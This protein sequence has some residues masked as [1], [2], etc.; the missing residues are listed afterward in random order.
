M[1]DFVQP[2]ATASLNNLKSSFLILKSSFLS[3]PNR[4]HIP[5]NEE[6]SLLYNI[7]EL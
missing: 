2:S 3:A 1:A 4:A 7:V 5:L 6:N